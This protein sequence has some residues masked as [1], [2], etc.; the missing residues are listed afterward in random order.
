MK[1][2]LKSILL[3]II[4]IFGSSCNKKED[5]VVIPNQNELITTL[6][7]TLTS[8]DSSEVKEFIFKDI[9][10]DGGSEPVITVDTLDAH[11]AYTGRIT[12]LNE[13][14]TPAGDITMEVEDE[15]TQHQ[16][17]FIATGPD[18][19][20]SYADTDENGNPLGLE[21]LVLTDSISEGTLNIVLRHQP[22][23]PNDGT[24]SDAGGSTDIT[25]DFDVFIR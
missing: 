22:N 7:Y 24:L 16:L 19:E 17:F 15:G 25:V 12:L 20:I 1:F 5:T 11:I 4:I 18:M 13:T 14:E 8:A 2:L 3:F 10:G 23:K 6:I 21:T 9:D